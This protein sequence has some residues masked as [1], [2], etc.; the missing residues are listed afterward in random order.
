M[1]ITCLNKHCLAAA[2]YMYTMCFMHRNSSPPLAMMALMP[3][4]LTYQLCVLLL[5]SRASTKWKIYLI[6][7]LM[8]V[9]VRSVWSILSSGV[10]ILCLSQR[11]NRKLT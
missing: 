7:T 11:G 10:G 9:V 5:M 6:I 4:Q 2:L 1:A 3:M 8:G